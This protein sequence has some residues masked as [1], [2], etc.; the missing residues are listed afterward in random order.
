MVQKVKEI[1]DKT[2]KG[3]VLKRKIYSGIYKS[4]SKKLHKLE[5]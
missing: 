4:E 2:G 1:H 3:R 5:T